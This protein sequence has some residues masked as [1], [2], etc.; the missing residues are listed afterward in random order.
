MPNVR[1]FVGRLAEDRL[2]LALLAGFAMLLMLVPERAGEL[3]GGLLMA[4]ALLSQA[5]SNVPATIF[6]N[7]FTEDWRTL[8][9][10][11]AVGGFG[12]AIG[13]LANLIA[14]RLARQAGLW[15][16]FHL[17]SVPVLGLAFGLAWYL[18]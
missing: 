3:P 14:L 9:W 2:L 16:E 18:I 1:F 8:A 5:I 13:S 4:G 11:V 6:L 15:R 10:A 12:T 17:W 7:A